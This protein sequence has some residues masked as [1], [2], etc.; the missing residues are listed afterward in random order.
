MAA[1]ALGLEGT[2]AEALAKALRTARLV[3]SVGVEQAPALEPYHDRIR[4][5]ALALLSPAQLAAHHLALAAAYEEGQGSPEVLAEHLVAAG[6]PE[7]ARRFVLEA[8]DRALQGLAFDRAA[9]LLAR[10]LTLAP[11]TR[12]VQVRLADALANAG[13][14]REAARAYLE[15]AAMASP[16]PASPAIRQQLQR[17][18][19]EQLLRTGHVDEGLDVLG[20]VLGALGERL[21]RSPRAALQRL[22]WGRAVLAMR[23]LEAQAGPQSEEALSRIDVYWS[24]AMG[25][26]MV[27]TIR[28]ASFQTQHLRVALRDAE[29]YR[30]CRALTAE[31]A[32]VAT[33]GARKQRRA[34]AL[35][36]RARPL[37]LA[38]GRPD[39][40][41]LLQ[42]ASGI[43]CFMSGQW[44]R[45]LEESDRA[46]HLLEEAGIGSTWEAKNAHL[47]SLWSLFYLGDVAELSRRLPA[48]R[49]EAAD[50]GDLYAMTGLRTGL[51]VVAHLCADRVHT[52]REEIVAGMERWSRQQF[53]FQHYWELLGTAFCALYAGEGGTALGYLEEAW[54]ALARSQLLRIQNVRVEAGFLKA[55]C[56]LAA[57]GVRAPTVRGCAGWRSPRRAGWSAEGVAWARALALLVR[58]GALGGRSPSVPRPSMRGRRRPA[59]ARTWPTTPP[60]HAGGGGAGAGA[61]GGAAGGGGRRVVPRAGH[62]IPGAH[63]RAPG[64]ASA[65][66]PKSTGGV[67]RSWAVDLH[68]V[69]LMPPRRRE[70][71]SS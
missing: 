12:E 37:A 43:V 11:P 4:Q 5:A 29:P 41:G 59:A 67:S 68:R 36:A 2:G 60:R 26:S 45:A 56:A 62:P 57:S 22:L 44:R 30:L 19:A 15:A 25:L 33:A 8:A 28:G 54:P 13:R 6:E 39:A 34:E 55:Q 64:R 35:I 71:K 66:A 24:L 49:R 53:H 58:A 17:R 48:L 63:D 61:G 9:V 46:W 7:R 1:R 27:D 65:V 51:A 40:Q 69:A 23:G 20:Q 21:D 52:A 70:A 31:A 38:S 14:G 3:R 47:F 42:M 32:Y 18:A 16:A 10:H 50:R